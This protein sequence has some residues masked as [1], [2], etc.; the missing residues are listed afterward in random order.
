MKTLTQSMSVALLGLSLAV[1]LSACNS[2]A[3]PQT[4]AAAAAAATPAAPVQV[5][6]RPRQAPRPKCY[7]C[8]TITSIEE[9]KAKGK[10]S[11]VG[12]VLGAVAGAVVGHQIGDGRGQ[13]VATAAGAVGGAYAGNEIEKRAK[14]TTYFHVT[15][16]MEHGGGSRTIDLDSMNGLVAGSHVKIVGTNLQVVA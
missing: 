15:I 5:A 3:E 13:D 11:G 1:P 9:M 12:L 2:S 16:A 14:G 7:D 8:G 10:G 4:A 6:S